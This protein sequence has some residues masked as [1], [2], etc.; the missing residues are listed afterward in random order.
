MYGVACN[1]SALGAGN[2]I[3]KTAYLYG[4]RGARDVTPVGL[5]IRTGFITKLTNNKLLVC[6]IRVYTD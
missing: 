3:P 6:A 5:A 2:D 4:Q 1:A